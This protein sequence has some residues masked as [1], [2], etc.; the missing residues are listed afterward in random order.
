MRT[1]W[2][3]GERRA[4]SPQAWIA[5]LDI[6][7]TKA[8][9]GERVTFD[10]AI[11]LDAVAACL[12]I[13]SDIVTMLPVHVFR[14]RNGIPQS[15]PAPRFVSDP[16]LVV[17]PLTWRAQAIV[18]MLLWGNAY[19]LVVE[20]DSLEYPRTVEWLDPSTVTPHQESALTPVEFELDGRPTDR[21]R[22]LHVRGRYVRPGSAIGLAPLERFKE[23]F[24]LAIAARNF[25]AR[26]FG[27]GAHPSGIL[28]TDQS[29]DQE[30]A[31]TMKERFL[32]AIRGKREP[33]VLGA[34][35]TY[36]QIQVAPNESQFNETQQSSI[37][38][39]ARSFGLPSE[40]IGAAMS[41]QNVTYANRE[42]RAIDTLTF[43]FDPWLVR[44]EAMWT[45]NMVA[46][47]YARFNRGALLRTD[48]LTRYRAHDLAIRG[49]WASRDER[50]E[51][52]DQAPIPDGTGGEFLW[53]PYR[54]TPTEGE[55]T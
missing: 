8:M 26:W 25:G 44:F 12:G 47:R 22:I 4:I 11:G 24:G 51:L 19:G 38:A 34:G 1:L 53:P 48:L 21:S 15:A 41:G 39:V 23:T 33:A 2:G 13:F 55:E 42:Q 29:V 30:Q 18:S 36:K 50:R 35:I 5:G 14:D 43:S 28:S 27:D 45:R 3:G 16:S 40:M 10:S 20:R 46:P 7:G 54:V 49:G 9:S 32:A 37:V 31:Q 17:D 6:G 52:E